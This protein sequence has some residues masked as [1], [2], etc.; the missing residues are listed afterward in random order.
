MALIQCPN[1]GNGISDKAPV[2]PKCGYSSN[3]QQIVMNPGL[4]WYMWL[5]FLCAGW[6]VSLVY[7]FVQKDKYPKK[8]KDALTCFWI[9][10]GF[11]IACT[12]LSVVGYGNY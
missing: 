7:Y 12:L 2:C 5:I 8:A 1:C 10:L 9:N 3:S 6:I 11:W 4:E